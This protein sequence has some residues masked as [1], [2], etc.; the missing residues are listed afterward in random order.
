MQ[1]E[2]PALL[3]RLFDP[4]GAGA[5][6]ETALPAAVEALVATGAGEVVSGLPAALLARAEAA[7][8]RALESR[9]VVAHG[10]ALFEAAGD[11]QAALSI[12]RL[13][14]G[15]ASFEAAGEIALQ[16]THALVMDCINLGSGTA[17]LRHQAQIAANGP[18]MADELIDRLWFYPRALR[19]T[20]LTTA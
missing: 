13:L 16:A 15:A 10:A 2:R 5:A 14:P 11:A 6:P 4:F 9:S 12:G 18:A 20:L 1:E 17:L 7:R 19:A 8:D 3:Y